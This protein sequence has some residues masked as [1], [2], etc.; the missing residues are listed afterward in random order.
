[1]A[2]FLFFFCPSNN[3]FVESYREFIKLTNLPVG[4]ILLAGSLLI[5]IKIFFSYCIK[6]AR[7]Y[8]LGERF[9]APWRH[10]RFWRFS[11]ETKFVPCAIRVPSIFGNCSRNDFRG[12][13][14]RFFWGGGGDQNSYFWGDPRS[15]WKNFVIALYS[16]FKNI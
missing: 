3:N 15:A 10:G 9:H 16:D 11:R 8:H 5:F 12:H 2:I 1:M 13:R 6:R 7:H 14:N 4:L